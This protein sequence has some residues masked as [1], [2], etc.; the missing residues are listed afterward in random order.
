[1]ILER[2]SILNYKNIEQA[3][4]N[5][6]PKINCFLG[7]NGMGKTNLLDTI[8]YLSFCKSYINPI[9]SQNI[10]HNAD[11]AVLQGWYQLEGKLE[12]FFCSLRRK[13]KKQFKR[14]KKEY[15]RLSDHIGLL[16][17]VM[18]SPSDTDLISGGSDERR[19]F[20]DLFL[21]QFDKEYL[22]S[23]I[24]YN[25]ALLQRNAL[26]KAD[27]IIDDTLLEL[28]DDQL[29]AE[30]EII[31]K[32]RKNFIK[33]FI[34]IFQKFYDFICLSNEKVELKYESHFSEGDFAS[35]LKQRREK[36]KIIGYTTVGIHKDD[37][38]MLMEGYS[39]KR[40][41]SQGQNKTYVVA[42]KLAQF[43]FLRKASSTTPILL[44]DDIFDKLDSSR[45]EQI[46]TLVLDKD[47]GQ[48]FIT[49]TNR[50]HLDDILSRTASDYHLYEV[51]K[52]TVLQ[53]NIS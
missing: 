47:F 39:I 2:L 38:D 49:D 36:D 48:I 37:L 50:Q 26:L 5:L 14:N 52:G 23:L 44:L 41:G 31:F 30:G 29:I 3:E 15:E 1:M 8:Y 51:E 27:T 11:F 22:H 32:K 7:S 34:P 21:S 19:K 16:P 10:N 24:R 43:D 9:D 42:L 45:V 40:V 20:M 12:E 46:I 6:S 18:V 35:L 28:W 13:Q 25:K 33:E 53:K 4:I 17:L